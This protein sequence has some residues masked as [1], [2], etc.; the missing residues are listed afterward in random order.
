MGIA[1]CG[2]YQNGNPKRSIMLPKNL[3]QKILTKLKFYDIFKV[4][5]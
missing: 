4:L 2:I 5:K 3:F 1:E